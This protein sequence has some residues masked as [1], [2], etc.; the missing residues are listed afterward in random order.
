MTNE[1]KFKLSSNLRYRVVA[2]GNHY[3]WIDRCT[4]LPVPYAGGGRARFKSLDEAIAA[5]IDGKLTVK[6]NV[7]LKHPLA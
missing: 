7:E 5:F 4:Q 6:Q 3:H 1:V 2:T